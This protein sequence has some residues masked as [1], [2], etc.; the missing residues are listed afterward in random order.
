MIAMAVTV[1]RMTMTS[2]VRL[3]LWL[4]A[5]MFAQSESD[6]RP[7]IVFLVVESTDGRTWQKDYQDNVVPLPNLRSL[8]GAVAFHKHYANSPVCCPSRATFWSGQH[9]HHVRNERGAGVWNNGE[10]LPH[11]Y[12]ERIDQ[13]LQRSATYTT[14]VAGKRDWTSGGHSLSVS[15]AAWTQNVYFPY[16]VPKSGG[17]REES[18]ECRSSGRVVPGN[19]TVYADDWANVRKGTTFIQQH[20][21]KNSTAPF[22]VFQGMNIVHPPYRTNEKYYDMIDPGK[23]RTPSWLPLNETHH[24]DFQTMLFK[25][26]LPSDDEAATFYSKARRRRLR[27]I[28]YAMIAEFDEMVGAYIRALKATNQLKNT[29]LIVTSDHGDLQMEHQQH[30]KMSA[31]DGSAR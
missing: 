29:V 6:Q 17:W 7:N 8:Y 12:N 5:L 21:S 3:L 31:Y 11:D 24:C 2:I 20:N 22:F 9:A 13:I 15:L 27:R 28:Y 30:Y 16:D 14:L 1:Q 18:A 4:A 19:R 26:C 23:I 10:G 25:G